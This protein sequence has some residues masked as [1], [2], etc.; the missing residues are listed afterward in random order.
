MT[1]FSISVFMHLSDVPIWR[2]LAFK[3][4]CLKCG[5]KFTFKPYQ[6]VGHIPIW[7]SA[8]PLAHTIISRKFHWHTRPTLQLFT[9][10][11]FL[12]G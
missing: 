8:Y 6:N 5:L 4:P 9:L 7:R 2:T 3:I 10:Y 11:G 12:I 1:Q